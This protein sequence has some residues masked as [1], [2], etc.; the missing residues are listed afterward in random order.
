MLDDVRRQAFR[1][2]M[3]LCSR[4]QRSQPFCH[5][6][7][8]TPHRPFAQSRSGSSLMVLYSPTYSPQNILERLLRLLTPDDA[9]TRV[10][11]TNSLEARRRA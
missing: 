10:Q 9:S 3:Q 2:F 6:Y 11:A 7:Q 4:P 1:S 8:T 5:F